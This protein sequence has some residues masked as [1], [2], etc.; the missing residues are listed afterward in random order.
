VE[1]DSINSVV[2]TG[3][4]LCIGSS[5][6]SQRFGVLADI[7]AR[8]RAFE[9]DRARVERVAP[10]SLVEFDSQLKALRFQ[11]RRLQRAVGLVERIVHHAS[12]SIGVLL[13]GVIAAVP[14]IRDFEIGTVEVVLIELVALAAP[15]GMLF[16][17]QWFSRRKA[18]ACF[19]KIASL[20]A[21]VQRAA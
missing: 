16:G 18:D 3:I 19:K 21:V 8:I 12:V 9:L 2:G 20:E 15:V 7:D 14:F 13:I 10:A 4:A 1:V 5:L 11:A 6:I 17:Y